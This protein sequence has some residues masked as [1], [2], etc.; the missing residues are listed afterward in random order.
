V[1][2]D[3]LTLAP[4][5]PKLITAQK[6]QWVFFKIHNNIDGNIIIN[7]VPKASA[8][9]ILYIN[10]GHTPPSTGI[11]FKRSADFVGSAIEISKDDVRHGYNIKGDYIIGLR[12]QESG[13]FTL[14]WMTSEKKL[15]YLY[16]GFPTTLKVKAGE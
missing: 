8:R 10:K 16:S 1:S 7:L 9:A 5:D 12:C 15:T 2:S 11:Y 4:Y 13:Q 6:D 14:Q 3:Y